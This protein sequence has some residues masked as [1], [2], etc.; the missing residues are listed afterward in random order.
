MCKG[1]KIIFES[2]DLDNPEGTLKK[3]LIMEGKISKPTNC[4]DFSFTH[5]QQIELIQ[6]NLR[7]SSRREIIFDQ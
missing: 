7:Q 6:G 1:F 2:F 3:S 5:K 4:L